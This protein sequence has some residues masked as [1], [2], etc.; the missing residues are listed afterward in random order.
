MNVQELAGLADW[1]EHEI[2]KGGVL[3][4]YQ[5]L[6]N[7]LS[8]NTQQNQQKV[9]FDSEK[10]KLFEA[11]TAMPLA[12]L[13]REQLSFLET[14][15]IRSSIGQAGVDDLEDA[16]YRNVIDPATSARI[17]QEKTQR[18]GATKARIDA[19]R[20]A[21]KD[22]PLD[23]QES[24]E[25]GVLFRV[26]FQ[27]DASIDDVVDLKKWSAAWHDIGRGVAM[28]HNESPEDVRVVGAGTGSIIIELSVVAGVALTIGK[29]IK[30]A[31][32]IAEQTNR[33]RIQAEQIRG[34]KLSNAKIASDLDKEAEK[35]KSEG[36]DKI[37]KIVAEGSTLEG[38]AKGDI[39]KAL[40][41]SVVK[42]LDFLD[43]GGRVDIIVRGAESEDADEVVL[44]L[45][46]QVSEIRRLEAGQKRITDA[47]SDDG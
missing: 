46:E 8:R 26:Y 13:S 34:M 43:K 21:L 29:I 39:A 12:K 41:T 20:T 37:N 5:A 2:H 25:G 9:S 44:A 4:Q 38:D 36:G 35:I 28:L 45:D 40:S 10:E 27:G 19:I 1:L 23:L 33:I 11:L 31:L 6:S 15:G 32:D 22:I 16:L 18:I 42:L 3:Q 47:R 17:V 30:E 24:G 14:I 7:A